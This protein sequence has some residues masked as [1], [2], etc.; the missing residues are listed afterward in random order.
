MVPALSRVATGKLLVRTPVQTGS[1][2]NDVVGKGRRRW[3]L[4][5]AASRQPIA[6]RLLVIAGLRLAGAIFLLR[7]EPA[8]VRSED[9]VDQTE[10]SV[11]FAEL[12]FRVGDDDPPLS[13][14]FG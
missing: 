11:D 9:L 14:V 13:G 8:R 12:K 6:Q 4:V 5:P 10:L 1:L 3:L 7:P 2:V